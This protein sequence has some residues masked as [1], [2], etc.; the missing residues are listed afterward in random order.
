[1]SYMFLCYD[2]GNMDAKLSM[3][4]EV[5]HNSWRVLKLVKLLH[6]Q[7][8]D[9]GFKWI[10]FRNANSRILKCNPEQ[11]N[12][13]NRLVGVYFTSTYSI[14]MPLFSAGVLWYSKLI[15]FVTWCI[16]VEARIQYSLIILTLL[17]PSE[18]RCSSIAKSFIFQSAQ[19][20]QFTVFVQINKILAV[21]RRTG[22]DLLHRFA[23]GFA[24]DGLQDCLFKFFSMGFLFTT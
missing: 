20:S 18:M 13:T 4:Y 19:L 10:Q 9:G 16:F 8:F 5:W 7:C 22:W 21:C 23:L 3:W 12:P 24:L 2:F 6:R 15:I 14:W 11:V 17:T 1:M